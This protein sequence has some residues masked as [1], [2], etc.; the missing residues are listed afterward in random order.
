MSNKDFVSRLNK[1]KF[2]E[3]SVSPNRS[4]VQNVS[5]DTIDLNNH[6]SCQNSLCDQQKR[7][8]VQNT[9][10]YQTLLKEITHQ[11]DK[12]EENLLLNESDYKKE[13]EQLNED[14]LKAK[15]EID[16]LQAKYTEVEQSFQSN[17]I[18]L[19]E[20]TTNADKQT[21]NSED[22]SKRN[23]ELNKTVNEQNVKII[24]LSQDLRVTHTNISSQKVTIS[25][26]ENEIREKNE[27]IEFQ[28]LV[29]KAKEHALEKK[30]TTVDNRIK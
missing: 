30:F 9:K 7:K 12:L 17:I 6:T 15:L 18:K 21:N 3:N 13:K 29:L 10:N 8:M 25:M 16:D 24:S 1:V 26:L 23:L 28:D 14:L 5:A 4:S 19:R 2:S 22:R 11:K 27:S 20:L